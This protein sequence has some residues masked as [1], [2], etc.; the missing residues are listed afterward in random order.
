MAA[1]RSGST[2]FRARPNAK[3]FCHWFS[4]PYDYPSRRRSC[5][6]PFR[7]SAEA[8][9]ASGDALA[10]TRLGLTGR[11]RQNDVVSRQP[12]AASEPPDRHRVQI[13]GQ[14]GHAY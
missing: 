10:S 3:G 13:P 12:V 5:R 4:F 6:S 1:A 11:Q 8:E 9:R 14:L 7:R 2:E